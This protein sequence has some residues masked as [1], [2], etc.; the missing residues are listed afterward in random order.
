MQDVARGPRLDNICKEGASFAIVQIELAL[1]KFN[2]MFLNHGV[3]ELKM[4]VWYL[5]LT[6]RIEIA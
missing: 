4:N 5:I 3:L 1:S 6:L 2:F